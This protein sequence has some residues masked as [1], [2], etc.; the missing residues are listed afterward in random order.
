M[1]RLTFRLTIT[2][3]VVFIVPALVHFGIWVM[4]DHP[5]SWRHADWTSAKM[6]PEAGDD[7]IAR[8]YILSAR[9]GGLKGAFSTHS[10]LVLKP[11]GATRYDRYDVVGWGR[12]V[13]K[14]AYAADARWYSNRPMIDHM[15]TGGVAEKLIP[16]IERAVANYPWQNKGD[17]SLWPG[18]NSNT[19]V[20]S[21]IRAVPEFDARTPTTAV[22]RDFP[23]NGRWI[24]F[25]RSGSL[26]ISTGGYAGL[27]LG[28]Q[29]G[30][31]VNFLGL[32]AGINPM[33]LQVKIPAFGTFGL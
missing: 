8:V 20:A 23:V 31:E 2:L 26:R 32:V 1:I 28:P 22:G 30:L 27:V 11:K 4:Q 3:V 29:D 9:T 25:D 18:P 5:A 6:L 16:A 17:Y 24:N 7:K 21:I 12:P 15:I 33:K 10:W 14:N 19:F 13:R